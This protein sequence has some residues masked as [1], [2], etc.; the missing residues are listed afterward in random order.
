MRSRWLRR[1]CAELAAEAAAAESPSE[2]QPS[3]EPAAEEPLR[4]SSPR[5]RT[6][7]EDEEEPAP[8]VKPAVPGAHLEVDIVPEGVD[9][10]GRESGRS[11]RDR[12][13][14]AARQRRRTEEALP[15]PISTAAIDLAAG[16][17]YRATGKRKT[18]IARVILRP[19]SGFYPINGRPSTRTSRARPSSAIFA[20]RWRPSATRSAWT[21]SHGCTAVASPRRPA[22]CATDLARA[23]RGRPEPAR[24][25]QAPR[26]P[27]AR[28]ARQGAQEG[29]SEEGA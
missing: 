2:E 15:E 16:A 26:L 18:A 28:L 12:G 29:R 8:R 1:V 11:L 24:R 4:R 5:M 22:R 27:D 20:S 19:G 6:S 17:R 14:R 23:A 21:S 7:R 10:L 25:A 3:A 9:P 13:P